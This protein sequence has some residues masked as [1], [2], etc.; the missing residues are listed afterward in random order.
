MRIRT[1]LLVAVVLAMLAT[2]AAIGVAGVV[3]SR[4]GWLEGLRDLSFAPSDAYVQRGPEIRRDFP[5]DGALAVDVQIDDGDVR[6]VGGGVRATVVV[7]PTGTSATQAGATAARASIR[8]D[9]RL[10]DGVLSVIWHGDAQPRP[11]SRDARSL[12]VTV[13]IPTNVKTTLTVGTGAADIAV[14]D[15]RGAIAVATAFGDLRLRDVSGAVQ[16]S[17]TSGDIDADGI[18]AG[19]AGLTMRTEFGDVR[20]ADVRAGS[21]RAQSSSGDVV[22]RTVETSGADGIVGVTRFGG[23]TFEGT[24]GRSTTATSDSGDIVLRPARHAGPVTA[25]TKF[26]DVDIALP[27]GAGAEVTLATRFGRITAPFPVGDRAGPDGGAPVTGRIGGGGPRLT[28]GTDSGDVRLTLAAD[29]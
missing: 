29:R 11:R 28:A 5:V 23:V 27:A 14:S 6:I 19:D 8:P 15:V 21:V 2:A 17:T 10:A 26:G 13:T 4:D 12:D 3:A 9:I 22:L 1:W 20:A 24:S 25:T 18:R 7:T 16:A